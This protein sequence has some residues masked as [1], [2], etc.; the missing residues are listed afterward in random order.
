[1]VGAISRHFRDDTVNFS[2]D[3]THYIHDI[4][5]KQGFYVDKSGIIYYDGE[6]LLDESK[7]D[8]HSKKRNEYAGKYPQDEQ[9][10][11]NAILMAKKVNV[12]LVEKFMPAARGLAQVWDDTYQEDS[13]RLKA[14]KIVK[15]NSQLIPEPPTTIAGHILIWNGSEMKWE[16][17]FN[18]QSRVS[19]DKNYIEEI[20]EK[21]IEYQEAAICLLAV[22]VDS[23]QTQINVANTLKIEEAFADEK[24]DSFKNRAKETLKEAYDVIE[25]MEGLDQLH[26][27]KAIKEAALAEN[28]KQLVLTHEKVRERLE[29]LQTV[30]NPIEETQTGWPIK[31]II[32]AVMLIALAAVYGPEILALIF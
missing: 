3:G 5:P 12:A 31:R 24:F 10:K 25:D 1:M 19:L 15:D 8:A 11:A 23:L 20:V 32:F 29:R 30:N 28:R 13:I 16:K 27:A 14:A 9:T 6:Q 22:Q 21:V 26:Q 18:N 2:K 17:T 7:F 4:I